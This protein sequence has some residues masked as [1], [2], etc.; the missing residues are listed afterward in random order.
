MNRLTSFLL[1]ILGHVVALLLLVFAAVPAAEAQD[2]P[3][4]LNPIMFETYNSDFFWTA[5]VG[6]RG[7]PTSQADT[8]TATH[9]MTTCVDA[10]DIQANNILNPTF[11]SPESC[12]NMYASAD[13]DLMNSIDFSHSR[14]VIYTLEQ[15]GFDSLTYHNGTGLKRVPDGYLTSI[16]LGDMYT[17]GS[18]SNAKGSEALFYTMTVNDRNS[19]LLINYAIVAR[20]YSHTAYDA[21]EF[22]IRVVKQNLDGTWPNAPINDNLWYKVDAPTFEGD[23]PAPWQQGAENGQA[24]S[25]CYKP[26]TTVAVSLA[27]YKGE[28]VRVEMYTS[29]CIY[30]FD[31][32]YAYICGDYVPM[33]INTKGCPQPGSNVIDTLV[34]PVGMLSYEWYGAEEGEVDIDSYDNAT[35]QY[36][37]T[38]TTSNIFTPQL[39]HFVNSNGDTL[40]IR[41]MRCVLTS[42]LD[43]AKPFESSLYVDVVNRSPVVRYTSDIDCQ[44]TATFTDQSVTFCNDPIDFTRTQWFIY[45]DSL[46]NSAPIDT[47]VGRTVSYTFPEAGNYAVQMLVYNGMADCATLHT[48]NHYVPPV[49][50]GHLTLD[51]RSHCE[52]EEAVLF[53]RQQYADSMNLSIDGRW[54]RHDRPAA[55]L[56]TVFP[57][58]VGPTP[59]ELTVWDARGCTNTY[60]DTIF[61]HGVPLMTADPSGPVCLGQSVTITAAGVPSYNWLATPRDTT[62]DSQQGQATIVVTP[63]T[64][65]LYTILAPATNRCNSTQQSIFVEVLPVP[66]PLIEF[67][68]PYIN[69][70]APAV[71]A[72]DASPYRYTTYWELSDGYTYVG[73]QLNHILDVVEPEAEFEVHMTSCNKANCCADTTQTI[74]VKIFSHYFPNVFMPAAD[75]NNRFGVVTSVPLEVYDLYIYNRQGQL[76]FQT[77]DPATLWDGTSGGKPCPQGA[78]AYTYRLGFDNSDHTVL[79]GRGLVTLLR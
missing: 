23:L 38:S 35:W 78:Y 73:P 12:A 18:G 6:D 49:P 74:G 63:D 11:D 42:A 3:G 37:Y 54:V 52:G 43:P 67:E 71:S 39:S 55:D 10:D 70:D 34:A 30:D 47:L 40:G 4:W 20:K 69:F 14:F 41:T 62:I 8:T 66:V 19:L 25:F 61:T 27:Q 17:C 22:I 46:T 58:R 60:R 75:A 32:L 1:A 79:T 64:S 76:V 29:D 7:R 16:K 77:T 21:G 72:I 68:N 56:D 33:I 24:T 15:Q 31:G 5:R 2:C 57:L 65:T 51:D 48:F 26:W 13:G 53:V 36:L 59:I 28:K 45:G 9:L 44:N 50:I